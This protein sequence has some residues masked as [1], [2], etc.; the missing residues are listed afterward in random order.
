VPSA[1]DRACILDTPGKTEREKHTHAIGVDQEPSPHS[2]P[3]LLAFNEFRR[4][5]VAMKGCGRCEAR[6]PSANNQYAFGSSHVDDRCATKR[7]G[8]GGIDRGAQIAV[9]PRWTTS[10]GSLGWIDSSE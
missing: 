2:T 5:A 7:D 3:S 4:E 6:Y 10:E 9:R 8:P 1:N